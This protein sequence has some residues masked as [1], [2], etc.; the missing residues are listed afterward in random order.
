[1]PKAKYP[2]SENQKRWPNGRP[3][4]KTHQPIIPRKLKANERKCRICRRVRL[5]RYFSFWQG[6]LCKRCDVCRGL[7]AEPTP[8]TML[9]RR[10]RAALKSMTDEERFKMQAI[11]VHRKL[12]A[13]QLKERKLDG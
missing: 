2:T 10:R 9:E 11:V 13:Q 8:T 1:M 6:K 3:M 4:R 12:K 5:L 7:A